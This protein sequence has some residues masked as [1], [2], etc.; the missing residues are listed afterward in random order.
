[1]KLYKMGVVDCSAN[2][3]KKMKIKC[4]KINLLLKNEYLPARN[5]YPLYR[6]STCTH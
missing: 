3:A 1:M 4:M 5:V 6:S 2:E